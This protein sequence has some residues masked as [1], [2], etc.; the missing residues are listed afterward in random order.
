MESLTT[1]RGWLDT[2]EADQL[3]LVLERHGIER[4]GARLRTLDELAMRL[5]HPGTMWQALSLAPLPI[6]EVVEAVSALGEAA[7]LARLTE[8]LDRAPAPPVSHE[9]SVRHWVDAAATAAM[10][11]LDGD[12]VR[13]NP[14]IDQ[15]LLAPLSLAQPARAT[16]GQ[17]TADELR[18]V[19]RGQGLDTPPRK[20]EL[21]TAAGAAFG[22]FAD[23][24]RLAATAPSTVLTTLHEV[25]GRRLAGAQPALA[26]PEATELSD[27]E[28]LTAGYYARFQELSRWATATG[29][30]FTAGWGYGL[31]LPSEVILALAP[32]SFHA[33]FHPE[34]P[35]LAT[36]AA[37]A[38]Q[39]ERSA[40]AA[41]AQFLGAAMAV[42]EG[43]S[44]T[45]LKPLKAGG[46]GSRE[47]TRFAKEI[48]TDM[49]TVRL[50]LEV[51]A[52]IGLIGLPEPGRL[53]TSTR[54]AEWRR[55]PPHVRVLD[56]VLAWERLPT[57]PT[58]ARDADDSYRPA[59]LRHRDGAAGLLG[60]E[61]CR[62]M[63]HRAGRGAVSI[64]DLVD[65]FAWHNPTVM[66]SAV[67]L[68]C[69]WNEAHLL[70]LLADGALSSL[71]AAI[72]AQD[73]PAALARLEELLPEESGQVLFG[74]DL[75][76]VVPGSPAPA[77]VDVLDLLGRREGHGVAN[78]WRL[79]EG[80]VRDA[81][82]AGYVVEDLVE[83]LRSLSEKAPPQAMEY[84]LRDV[85]RKHGRLSVRPAAAVLTS[86]DEG[87]LAEVAG[88]R[89]LRSLG[90]TIV[91]PT[92]LVATADPARVLSGLRAA[93]Y[94]PIEREADGAP[95]MEIR[96]LRVAGGGRAG[97]EPDPGPDPAPAED[98]DGGDLTAELADIDAGLA[99]LLAQAPSGQAPRPD[100]GHETAVEL[101]RRLLS[102]ESEPATP[103]AHE[104]VIA[105]LARRL[106][107]GEVHE[108][109]D[110]VATSRPV[111]LTYR[112]QHGSVTSRVVS[113]LQFSG[114][115]L[116]GYCHTKEAERYF[117]LD[118][119]LGVAP[120]G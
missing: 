77:T 80:S 48:G 40:S 64:A 9:R 116:L 19:L 13:L 111:L 110:A 71:G 105:G 61:L 39:T 3:A 66:V 34:P 78:T 41:L 63:A 93:G 45:G 27:I 58:L 69:S 15:V 72:T 113:R 94:L 70:G 60:I 88:E 73:R 98:P 23:L 83:A 104:Q 16:I 6:L 74:S 81:L 109:V 95:V 8:L 89:R 37:A 101:A 102:G 118:R 56:I 30:A 2:L 79:S 52:D 28:D 68:A 99:E 21:M 38:E 50:T 11:W 44:R 67:D 1:L 20:A 17:L 65:L 106:N 119:I 24:R 42:L 82:D 75:T 57:P 22:R 51:A 47:L 103:T 26:H 92:V 87:L 100:S 108:L 107:E 49:A 85:A 12:R 97:T 117:R 62:H 115:H 96:R 54:F 7:T 35:A 76:V 90:L 33:P 32:P 14:G 53:T 114:P 10:L 36:V 31:T 18:A 59:L 84:L 25:V 5:E 4:T 86:E 91:T 46:V 43:L 29:L 112:S 120:A 55:R